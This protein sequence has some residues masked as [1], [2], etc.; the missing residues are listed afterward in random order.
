VSFISVVAVHFDGRGSRL[1]GLA[2]GAAT[3]GVGVGAFV[4]PALLRWLVD[5][6]GWRGALLMTAGLVGQLCVAAA[7]LRPPQTPRRPAATTRDDRTSVV[8]VASSTSSSSGYDTDETHAG[9]QLKANS[10]AVNERTRLTRHNTATD[11]CFFAFVSDKYHA[12]KFSGC[13][14]VPDEISSSFA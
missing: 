5:E 10:L 9:R 12:I 7:A 14:C 4:Y 8:S 11:V 6:Y 13:P 3:T 2:F 1:V